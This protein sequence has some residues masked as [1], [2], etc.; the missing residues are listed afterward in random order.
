M[1]KLPRCVDLIWLA[2]LSDMAQF[3]FGCQ[4]EVN[5]H[6]LPD[7]ITGTGLKRIGS[8]RTATGVINGSVIICEVIASGS[9]TAYVSGTVAIV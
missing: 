3:W 6:G 7:L 4:V 5:S 2:R 8:A 1:T 9:D